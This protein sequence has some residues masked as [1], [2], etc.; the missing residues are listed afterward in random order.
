MPLLNHEPVELGF[1]ARN[2]A[3]LQA[4]P[5]YEQAFADAFGSP[6][7]TLDRVTQAL[8][9]YVRTLQAPVTAFDRFLYHDE[10][11]ALSA[12]ARAGLQLFT[13]PRLGC[14]ACHGVPGP[15]EQRRRSTQPPAFHVTGV[16]ASDRAFRVPT[17]RAV[18][19]T[20]PY[21]HDGSLATLRAVL[22]HYE[23]ANSATLP[24]F[25]LT[26]DERRALLAFLES[27]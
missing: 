10:A 16:G 4:D 13:S 18:R 12:D 27:L 9:S 20:A 11:D 24:G 14:A 3:T 7:I 26:E 5:G 22:D 25:E 8:A 1:S 15:A 21:M 23:R 19:H 2:R 6:H 17:L